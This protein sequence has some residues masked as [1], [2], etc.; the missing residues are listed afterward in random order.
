MA[1]RT[2]QAIHDGDGRSATVS[3]KARTTG[4]ARF[5]RLVQ[6]PIR[7]S[8]RRGRTGRLA[9]VGLQRALV[10]HEA[11]HDADAAAQ[12]HQ[13]ERSLVARHLAVHARRDALLA[14]PLIDAAPRLTR[15]RQDHRHLGPVDRLALDHAAHLALRARRHEQERRVRDHVGQ[16]AR[17]DALRQRRDGHVDRVVLQHLQRVHRVAGLEP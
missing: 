3:Q 7:K 10:E 8:G 14:E 4:E 2:R 12:A 1:R 16:K 13:R 15:L 5:L 17:P 6:T 9:H 11:R